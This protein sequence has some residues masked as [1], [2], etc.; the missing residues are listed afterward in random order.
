V[1]MAVPGIIILLMALSVFGNSLT[2][3][4]IALGVLSVP[5]LARV[6]RSATI[7]VSSELYVAA[8]RVV[9]LKPRQV[10]WRPILP[11]G[12]GP[13]V[14]TASILCGGALLVQT[15]LAFLEIGRASCRE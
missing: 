11:R 15:G 12:V 6:V 8:A 14:V 7:A 13:V 9:G 1:L 3:A 10:M 4:M 5:S 2:P